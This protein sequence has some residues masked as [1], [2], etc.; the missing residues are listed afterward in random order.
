MV[1]CPDAAAALATTK[2]TVARSGSSDDRVNE[3]QNFPA[4]ICSILSAFEMI[5]G[6]R[7]MNQAMP[8]EP[9]PG[10]NIH[11]G[12]LITGHELNDLPGRQPLQ[13]SLERQQHRPAGQV[14]GIPGIVMWKRVLIHSVTPVQE[15]L[16]RAA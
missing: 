1:S 9:A 16:P 13:P 8:G 5:T 15:G 12:S 7:R 14:A 10:G 6:M 2:A 11:R 4:M 3:T